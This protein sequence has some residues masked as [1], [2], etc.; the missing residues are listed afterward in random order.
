MITIEPNWIT[1]RSADTAVFKKVS[2]DPF[3]TFDPFLGPK[4]RYS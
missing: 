3:W 2:F 1:I 4:S